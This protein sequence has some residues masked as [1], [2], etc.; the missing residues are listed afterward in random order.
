MSDIGKIRAA[1]FLLPDP[2]GPVV[3]ELCE[4]IKQL[5]EKLAQADVDL[6]LLE[7]RIQDSQDPFK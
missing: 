7:Q 3:R 1:S 4:E 6:E 5:Q 2:G